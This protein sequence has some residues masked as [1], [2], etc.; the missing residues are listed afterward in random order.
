MSPTQIREYFAGLDGV[1][2]RD[3]LRRMTID[4][5]IAIESSPDHQKKL[6]Q[7][8]IERALLRKI[9]QSGSAS[10]NKNLREQII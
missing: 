5:L 7:E 8:I 3:Y 6:D 1:Q 10:P 2:R 9:L 4:Q